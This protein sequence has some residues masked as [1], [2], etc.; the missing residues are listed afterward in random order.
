MVNLSITPSSTLH[1]MIDVMVHLLVHVY[2]VSNNSY[3]L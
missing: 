2:S 1:M 3:Q